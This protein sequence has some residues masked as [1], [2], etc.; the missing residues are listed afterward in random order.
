[1][2]PRAMAMKGAKGDGPVKTA[3]SGAEIFAEIREK[4][5][6][7]TEEPSATVLDS[8]RIFQKWN[9]SRRKAD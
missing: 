5:Y 6:G 1:M 2:I 4:A 7:D 8:V 9:R 3:K